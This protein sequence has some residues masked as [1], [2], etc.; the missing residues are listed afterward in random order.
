MRPSN[1]SVI[2]CVIAGWVTGSAAQVNPLLPCLPPGCV[3]ALP[4]KYDLEGNLD[5]A[6]PQKHCPPEP[7]PLTHDQWSVELNPTGDDVRSG[8]PSHDCDLS[9]TQRL[10]PVPTALAPTIVLS[11]ARPHNPYS[12]PS[13]NPSPAPNN[14]AHDDDADDQ[15]GGLADG[16][17]S[18]RRRL[19]CIK[20]VIPH[21]TKPSVASKPSVAEVSHPVVVPPQWLPVLLA[22]S[23]L[24]LPPPPPSPSP[25]PSP[26]PPLMPPPPPPSPL[27]PPPPLLPEE[28]WGPFYVIVKETFDSTRNC[29]VDCDAN[30]D[31]TVYPQLESPCNKGSLVVGKF[32]RPG[33]PLTDVVILTSGVKYEYKMPPPASDVFTPST[34]GLNV[35]EVDLMTKLKVA[36]VDNDGFNDLIA[37][38]VDGTT[39]VYLNPGTNDFS[40]VTPI[41]IKAPDPDS[42]KPKTTDVVVAD[43]NKD[44]MPD[45]VTVND[46]GENVLYLGPLTFNPTT[47]EATNPG[48][49]LGKD[50]ATKYDPITETY[51]PLTTVHDKTP[52]QSVQVVD[53]DG[54]IGDLDIVVGNLGAPNV[55]YF[56][57]GVNTGN[58]PT[59]TPIGGTFFDATSP[60]TKVI[61]ADLDNDGKMDLVVA[62]RDEEN[63]IFLAKDATGG[64]LYEA[65]LPTAPSTKLALPYYNWPN[66]GLCAEW[67]VS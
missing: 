37:T 58:F 65:S 56:Q 40:A 30:P 21:M 4:C 39:K 55:V 52:T 64:V 48:T 34:E 57:E 26:P 6:L 47:M 59:S 60:T 24:A 45:I 41:V 7:P 28:V 35:P 17:D 10:I 67:Q 1:V 29:L 20:K 27:P 46:G 25:A 12:D 5:R 62:N 32:A 38:F 49:I 18:G 54:D 50:P 3:V 43:V 14:Q 19:H 31:T 33:T 44:G 8:D 53:V 13:P 15:D 51:S 66:G 9:S 42:V 11:Y 2:C 61:V 16:G 22:T 36:D 63:Q 23:A